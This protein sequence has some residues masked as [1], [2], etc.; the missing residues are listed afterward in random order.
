[1]ENGYYFLAFNTRQGRPFAD[2]RVR[3]ALAEAVDLPQLARAV[4]GGQGAPIGSSIAPGS[5]ADVIAPPTSTAN[6]DRARALLDETGWKLPDGG[7]IPPQN[8][9]ALT[10]H[11]HLRRDEQRSV[12][13]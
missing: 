5:W 7:S 10:A 3:D 1:P 2:P 8:W 6:L 12:K 13:E 9:G 4:T 11:T